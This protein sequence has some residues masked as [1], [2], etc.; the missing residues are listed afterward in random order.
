MQEIGITQFE[1]LIIVFTSIKFFYAIGLQANVIF[2]LFTRNPILFYF[3]LANVLETRETKDF[4]PQDW[5]KNIY[6]YTRSSNWVQ[7]HV[8]AFADDRNR[9][10]LLKP[11]GLRKKNFNQIAELACFFFSLFFYVMIFFFWFFI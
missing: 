8:G 3:D 11:T 6:F 4:S 7:L 2:F 5:T 10:K 9:L 1:E